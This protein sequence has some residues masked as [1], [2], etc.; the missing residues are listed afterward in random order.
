MGLNSFLESP[1]PHK[2]CSSLAAAQQ[3]ASRE[4][5]DTGGIVLRLKSIRIELYC[6]VFTGLIPSAALVFEHPAELPAYVKPRSVGT[7]HLTWSSLFCPS[8]D[9]DIGY[10]VL[11]TPVAAA[12]LLPESEDGDNCWVTTAIPRAFHTLKPAS[13]G[14]VCCARCNR[15]IP[16]QR[17]LAVPHTQVC[18]H[19]QQK[20][21]KYDRSNQRPRHFEEVLNT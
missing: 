4:A 21:E 11:Q 18:T 7:L 3:Q 8:A 17:L 6:A 13:I 9:E 15:P 12:G 14:A 2:F 5:A 1:L 19:C 20:K 10:L 16:P